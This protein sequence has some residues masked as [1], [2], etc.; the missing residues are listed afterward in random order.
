MKRPR[1]PRH[2]SA[3]RRVVVV[4]P[5]TRLALAR[6]GRGA[7]KVVLPHDIDT[8]AAQ[9]VYTRQ[10]RL[11][12]RS[13]AALVLLVLGLPLLL[14]VV[15]ELGRLRLGDVPVS[16]L[17]LGAAPYPLLLAVAWVHLRA[18]ERTERKETQHR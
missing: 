3:P 1:G 8:A 17:L 10:R 13:M 15:P 2:M 4:S 18:A 7:R 16:W 11:A 14:A 6:H 5:Q 9:A 12:L